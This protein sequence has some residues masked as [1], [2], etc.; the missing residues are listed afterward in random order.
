M[1]HSLAARALIMMAD[2][3][4]DSMEAILWVSRRL[5]SNMQDYYQR[6]LVRLLAAELW[7]CRA[8]EVHA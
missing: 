8:L 1:I 4:C 7:P 5:P 3:R 2:W 6:A